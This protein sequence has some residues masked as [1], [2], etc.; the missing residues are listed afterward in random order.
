M[1]N[2]KIRRGGFT[3]IELMLVLVILGVLAAIV[4]P[5]LAGRS[6]EAKIKATKAEISIISGALDTFEVDNGRYPTTEEGLGALVE[7]PSNVESWRPYLK[8][9]MPVDQWKREYVYVYPGR[10]N[11]DSFDLYSLGPDGR[12][13]QDDINNWTK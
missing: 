8:G 5:K 4:V 11:P 2:G 3:L 6:E 13:G 7:Q 10:N 1:R 12:E 9:G